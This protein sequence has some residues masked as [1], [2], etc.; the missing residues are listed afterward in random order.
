MENGIPDE[1]HAQTNPTVT[2]PPDGTEVSPGA[3]RRPGSSSMS[4]Q[5]SSV[6]CPNRAGSY[7]RHASS[8]GEQFGKS[9]T[10]GSLLHLQ[11]FTSEKVKISSQ[12]GEL[13]VIHKAEGAGVAPGSSE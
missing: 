7:H 11:K 12:P 2:V 3:A 1:G 10:F 5:M 4:S 13:Q 9:L 8:L 6:S